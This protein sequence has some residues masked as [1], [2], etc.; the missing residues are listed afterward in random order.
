MSYHGLH[1]APMSY[2]GFPRVILCVPLY[3]HSGGAVRYCRTHG[4]SLG[5]ATRMITCSL[6]VNVPPRVVFH[7]AGFCHSDAQALL[8]GF[9]RSTR[10]HAEQAEEDAVVGEVLVHLEH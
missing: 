3:G 6:K 2:A 10:D 7:A 9:V 5:Y 1:H 4:G 8:E